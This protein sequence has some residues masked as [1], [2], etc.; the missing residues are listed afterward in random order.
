MGREVSAGPNKAQRS[1]WERR[2]H[3]AISY[4]ICHIRCSRCCT[5]P[6]CCVALSA[7]LVAHAHVHRYQLRDTMLPSFLPKSLAHKVL[8]TGKAINFLR[9][10]CHDEQWVREFA[11]QGRA[12]ANN[13]A[14]RLA[15]LLADSAGS[16]ETAARGDGEHSE[17]GATTPACFEYGEEHLSDLTAVVGEAEAKV[18]ARLKTVLVDNYDFPQHCRA[19]QS[20]L[21]LKQGDFIQSLMTLVTEGES[22]P[23]ILSKD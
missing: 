9:A 21:L 20:F 15:A 11:R 8:L 4:R 10:C 17:S 18:S 23:S 3:H 16:E 13:G 5:G 14:S 19:L 7:A 12:S 6:A 22:L 1:S 2:A